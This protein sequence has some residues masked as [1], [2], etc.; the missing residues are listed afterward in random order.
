M[1]VHLASFAIMAL[2]P[3]TVYAG[4][5]GEH[6][7]TEI[8]KE[9]FP[10]LYQQ[11]GDEWVKKMNDLQPQAAEMMAENQGC[12]ILEYLG[13]SNTRS[14]VKKEIVFFGDCR[15]GSRFYISDK[16]IDSG[17]SLQSQNERQDAISDVD[18]ISY[19]KEQI[20]SKLKFP[21]SFDPGWFGTKVYRAAA[22]RTVATVDFEAKNSLGAQLPHRAECFF[23][24]GSFSELTIKLR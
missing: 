22:G 6:A 2:L 21:S 13:P 14:V 7:V 11:W 18:F 8:T 12:D 23:E 24:G 10:T 4:T 3:L 19:C 16:E 20:K 5:V 9:E 17:A 15:N 1:R